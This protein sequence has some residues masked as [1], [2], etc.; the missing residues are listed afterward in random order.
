MAT[1]PTSDWMS[2]T[3]ALSGN[4]DS[5]TPPGKS[6]G[7]MPF[8][9][10]SRCCATYCYVILVKPVCARSNVVN[11]LTALLGVSGTDGI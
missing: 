3:V 10:A 2:A 8:K 6:G 5:P 9:K 4:S 11:Y 1:L 7:G